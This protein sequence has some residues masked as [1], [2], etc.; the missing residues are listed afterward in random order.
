MKIPKFQSN[1]FI[2]SMEK[3]EQSFCNITCIEIS[4]PY[5]E[6]MNFHLWFFT[7]TT[8][9]ILSHNFAVAWTHQFD[10]VFISLEKSITYIFEYGNYWISAIT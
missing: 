8:Y 6:V 5:K 2:A 3:C 9:I 10:F 1:T 7:N 4:L